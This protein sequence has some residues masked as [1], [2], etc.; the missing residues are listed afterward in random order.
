M[1][2]KYTIQYR[3][4][5][6]EDLWDGVDL[7]SMI[8][9]VLRRQ[10]RGQTVGEN[11]RLRIIDLD[12]D[13]SFVILNKISDPASWGGPVFAGQI[14]HLQ[15]GSEVQAVLQSLEE[16][17][18]EFVLQSLDVGERARVLK[19]ALY[20]AV[21]GNPVGLIEGQ[22]VRG[23]LLERYLTASLQQAEEIEPGQAIIL[24]G[25][26]RSGDGKE[27]AESTEIT[28]AAT[29]N[30]GPVAAERAAQIVEQEAARLRQEGATVFD[31]LRTLGWDQAAVDSLRAEVPDDGWIEGFFRVLIKQRNRKRPISRATI[32]EALRNIDPEDIGLRGDGSE[33]GGIVKLS[34]QKSIRTTGS[35]IDPADAMEQIVNALREWAATGK[36]DCNFDG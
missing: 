5:K 18:G 2:K 14:I 34:T 10:R 16:D 26:F 8:V 11:A 6:T 35:L 20:F 29:P 27:L 33:K 31:V 21:V 17:T 19:G 7:K 28:V 4:L 32:N 25:S 24:N 13:N 23:R 15:E 9:D 3:Q 1:A 12:Q 36:I 30:M 22:Q